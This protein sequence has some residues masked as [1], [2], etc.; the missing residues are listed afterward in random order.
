MEARFQGYR[1]GLGGPALNVLNDGLPDRLR[2]LLYAIGGDL[3]GTGRLVDAQLNVLGEVPA[4]DEGTLFDR[5]VLR[6]LLLAGLDEH[7]EFDK[8]LDRFDV[9][10]DGTVRVDYA[11]GTTETADPAV[12][13]RPGDPA[14]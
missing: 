10:A 4:Q 9:L 12:A 5:H 11:D 14:R 3:T 6:M 7:I 8:K 1:I 13:G 2:P